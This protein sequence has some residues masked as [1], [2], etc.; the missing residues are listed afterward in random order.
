[1]FRAQLKISKTLGLM[2]LASFSGLLS[3]SAISQAW[4]CVPPKNLPRPKI[5]TPKPGEARRVP[6]DGYLLALSWS[7][8][9]CRE[10]ND[11]LQC[12]G[13]MGDFG[14]VL[15]GLWP[16]GKGRDYPMWCKKADLLP[17]KVI[18]E[19]MCMTPSVQ[20]LQHE[21]AKHGTCMARTPQAY[22]GAAK[23]LY[24]AVVMPDMA[25]LSRQSA[26]KPILNAGAVAEAFAAINPGLPA[27][28]LA[29]HTTRTGWLK[30]VRV[31]LGNDLK[32]EICGP[33]KKGAPDNASVKVWRGD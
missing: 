25:Q 15:H 7:P 21:W 3:S 23:L 20:L 1:V 22:F 11:D 27:K 5:E 2:L 33:G 32:P 4:Q 29:V 12:S 17:R 26:D 8:E 24:D 10:N 31:C 19:H 30:E 6:V 28:A 13:K 14:F 16:E 18:A 9:H